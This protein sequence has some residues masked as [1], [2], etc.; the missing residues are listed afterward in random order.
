[1]IFKKRNQA[2]R[3][4]LLYDIQQA[5]KHVVEQDDTTHRDYWLLTEWQ[6]SIDKYFPKEK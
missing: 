6:A 1:M 5:W 2:L 3:Q 4:K